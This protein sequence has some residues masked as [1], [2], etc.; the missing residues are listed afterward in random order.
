[1]TDTAKTETAPAA[2][3]AAFDAS[4]FS[5]P[6]PADATLADLVGRVNALTT[7]VSGLEKSGLSADQLSAI[8]K[9]TA[10][11]SV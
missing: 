6:L 3:P 7:V 4:D 8:D 11:F 2:T 10:F 9:I 1:M 5:V